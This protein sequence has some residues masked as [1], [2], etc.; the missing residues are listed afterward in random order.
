M[1]GVTDKKFGEKVA[2][3]ASLTKDSFLEEAE[4]IDFVKKIISSYKVPKTIIF[5]NKIERA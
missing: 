2:A 3:V 5:R 1:I 4:L